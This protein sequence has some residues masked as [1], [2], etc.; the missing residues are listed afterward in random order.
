M[1]N[2]STK[3]LQYPFLDHTNPNAVVIEK[4]TQNWIEEYDFLTRETKDK[5][6]NVRSGMLAARFFP[7]A[8]IE[9]LIPFARF[10][11]WLFIYD[12]ICGPYPL[13][14]L[15]NSNR[16]CMQILSGESLTQSDNEFCRQLYHLKHE[17]KP[18]ISIGLMMR[19]LK[20]VQSYFQSMEVDV[21]HSYHKVNYPTILEYIEIRESIAATHPLVDF[22]EI[23]SA[24]PIPQDILN[25]SSLQRMKRLVCRMVAWCND[26][27][28]WEKELRDKE[29]MNIV[30]VI[31]H[32]KQCTI[33]NALK[34][35]INFHDMDLQEFIDLK[36]NLPDFG[37]Y[38]EAVHRYIT[39]LELF[40]QGHVSWYN[41]TFRY[42]IRD[43]ALT[44]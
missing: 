7:H 32:E 37:G 30:L 2:Q 23:E 15:R 25:F 13:E 16:R 12:D 22:I 6:K 21:K 8:P 34:E 41:D 36:N 18:F 9:Q 39:C 24:F 40:L 27:Y 35:A 42:K 4:M 38:N 10:T 28:S 3:P 43:L 19:F 11:L 33:S 5:F 31:R 44:K 14:Q 17:L 1:E 26:V 20:N 29:A